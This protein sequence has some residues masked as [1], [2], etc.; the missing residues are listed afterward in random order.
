MSLK[1]IYL[2]L[3]VYALLCIPII[4][5]SNDPTVIIDKLVPPICPV[6]TYSL[7]NYRRLRKLEGYERIKF[8]DPCL[9]IPIQTDTV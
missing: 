4:F 2:K 6:Y 3:Y 7:R 1:E 8:K 9:T 5:P